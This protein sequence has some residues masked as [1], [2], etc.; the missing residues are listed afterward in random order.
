MLN[1]AVTLQGH[2][3]ITLN[4]EVAQEIPNLVV[5][6]GKS[7]VATR[8]LDNTENVMSHMAIGTTETDSNAA[9]TTLGSENAR[10]TLSST[11]VSDNTI[12]YVASF[13]AGV[14]NG[15][16]KEAGV[17]NN[18][19]AGTM[20]CRTVFPVVNKGDNDTMAITWTIT[21]S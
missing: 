10:V 1:S 11:T 19:S 14:G 18:S 21:A 16:I 13:G 2:V 4:G 5:A 7:F 20:L 9:D 3:S 12:T 17:F 15:P 6:S 8:M